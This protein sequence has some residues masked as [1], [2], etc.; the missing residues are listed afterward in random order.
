MEKV[1]EHEYD[2]DGSYGDIGSIFSTPGN[3]IEN[4]KDV[5]DVL[6]GY[7]KNLEFMKHLSAVELNYKDG[8]LFG[9]MPSSI[10]SDIPEKT[11]KSSQDN[12]NVD[13]EER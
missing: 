5:K 1:F 11:D 7:S 6:K 10:K 13:D 8:N 2:I 4:G 12:R 3:Y 9:I